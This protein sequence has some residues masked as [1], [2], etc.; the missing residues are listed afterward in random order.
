MTP[1]RA[2]A[3]LGIAAVLGAALAL[4]WW[5]T[6]PPRPERALRAHAAPL[7][8]L[9]RAAIPGA[10]GGVERWRLIDTRG[11]TATALWRAATGASRPWTVVMLGGL[12]TG[13]RAALL[14]PPDVP[15]N[16]L[17]L[18]WPWRGPTRLSWLKGI[19]RLG[20]IR[21]AVLRVPGVLALGVEAVTGRPDVDSTRIVLLGASLG[22]PPAAAAM[23]LTRRPAALV[24]IDGAADLEGLLRAGL[25][26]ERVPR[27][28]AGP[29]AALA[30]RLVRPLEPTLNAPA[31]P[32]C[33]MLVNAERDELLPRRCI[34][35][36]HAAYPMAT[37]RWR[38]EPHVRPDRLESIATMAREV[39]AWLDS[40][41][42]R[43]ARA[44]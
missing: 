23:R 42:A 41:C 43:E 5:W 2:R 7:A 20:A 28:I 8:R 30:A 38:A 25:V 44:P 14:L 32:A 29:A 37:V 31:A 15:V 13:E 12:G 3:T 27:P 9:E 40:A 33:V 34:D 24:L 10:G 39:D 26:R 19:A 4:A 36:L 35:R 22:V 16:A 6:H 11:D 1:S 18:D 17:A 21:E